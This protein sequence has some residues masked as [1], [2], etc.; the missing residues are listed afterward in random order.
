MSGE[1][2][3]SWWQDFYGELKD[4]R[5]MRVATLYVVLFWPVIQIRLSNL[6]GSNYTNPYMKITDVFY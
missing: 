5:V 2:Q 6:F 4:R 1:T 3:Q